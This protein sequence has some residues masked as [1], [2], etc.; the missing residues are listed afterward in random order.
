MQ[1]QLM[2]GNLN[3]AEAAVEQGKND[4]YRDAHPTWNMQLNIAEAELALSQG[5]YEQAIAI[6][7]H[8][9]PRLRQHN[10]RAYT[11]AM[12]QPKSQA[13]LVLGQVEAARESLLEARDIA[14]A[15]GS[16]ATLWPILAALSALEPDP[17]AAQQLHR[18]AQE[19]VESIVV[20]LAPPTYGLPSSTCPRYERWFRRNVAKPQLKI[21]HGFGGSHGLTRIIQ[22]LISENP[23]NP[24]HPCSLIYADGANLPYQHR[25]A[26]DLSYLPM[27]LRPIPPWQA[28]PNAQHTSVDSQSTP[29][30]RTPR[31]RPIGAQVSPTLTNALFAFIKTTLGVLLVEAYQALGG[32]LCAVAAH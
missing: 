24:C 29:F 22:Y 15:T 21:G 19:I 13:Q 17:T 3:E 8:W 20:T 5:N 9:L 31:W 11:P 10:L 25:K 2:A 18:Q 7:D 32:D 12:F 1:L 6:A 28:W 23:Y 27:T 16:R 26:S 30:P 14:T 4:P